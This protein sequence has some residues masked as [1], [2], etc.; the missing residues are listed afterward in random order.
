MYVDR[1]QFLLLAASMAAGC[2]AQGAQSAP[3]TDPL[4]VVATP[5]EVEPATGE[6]PVIVA[7][8]VDGV[9]RSGAVQPRTT[10]LAASCR[11]IQP[12]PGP[13]CESFE[14]TKHDCE[15]YAATLEP[16]AAEAATQCLVDRS[17]TEAICRFEALEECFVAG[18]RVA[19]PDGRARNKCNSL[20]TQCSGGRW[21]SPDLTV[22][23]CELA[24]A[25]VK[26]E[27]D[28]ELVSCMVEG[29]GISSCIWGL[30]ARY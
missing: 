13:F 16:D 6:E 18:L 29:C 21:A 24:M 27:H 26:D 23:S 20:V 25:A 2:G 15:R 10:D 8:E 5:I 4:V 22:A 7:E 11:G 12:P 17:G 1:K 28:S 3:G 30:G 9:D 19:R 14:D